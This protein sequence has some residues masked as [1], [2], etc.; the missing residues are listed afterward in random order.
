MDE[1]I[2]DYE[3]AEDTKELLNGNP[4]VQFQSPN[5]KKQIYDFDNSILLKVVKTINSPITIISVEEVK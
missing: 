2:I 4:D 3:L 5:I 1:Q